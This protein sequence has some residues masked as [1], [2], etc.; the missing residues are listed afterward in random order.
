M[1]TLIS[2][3]QVSIP[4]TT[5]CHWNNNNIN[6]RLPVLLLLLLVCF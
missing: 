4:L 1:N 5:I 3:L 6:C 2:P